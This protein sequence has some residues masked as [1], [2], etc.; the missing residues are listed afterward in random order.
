MGFHEPLILLALVFIVM[1]V[2][3]HYHLRRSAQTVTMDAVLILCGTRTMTQLRTVHVLLLLCRVLVIGLIVLL[4]SRPYIEVPGTAGSITERPV[5]LALVLDNSMSMRLSHGKE[6]SWSIAR[7]KAQK[8]LADLPHRSSVYLV[9][10]QKTPNVLFDET[11]PQGVSRYIAR[12]SPTL[13]GGDLCAAVKAAARLVRLTGHQERH[14]VVISDFFDHAFRSSLEALDLKDIRVT[15]LDVAPEGLIANR[16]VVDAVAFPAP[17]AGPNHVKV[18]AVVLNDQNILFDEVVTASIGET[19]VARRLVCNP[20]SR[21]P[22][23]FLLVASP[24]ELSGEVWISADNLPDDDRRFFPLATRDQGGI[25]LVNGA[26]SRIEK[27]DETFFLSRALSARVAEMQSFTIT[28]VRPEELSPLHLSTA[29][30]VVLANVTRLMPDQV[31]AIASFVA[32]GHGL[33]VTMGDNVLIE[34]E[35]SL[36]PDL[37][38]AG[39]RDVVDY[40]GHEALRWGYVENHP[41]LD[42]LFSGPGSLSS[43]MVNRYAVLEGSWPDNTRVIARLTNDAPIMVERGLGKGVVLVLLTS[44][45]RDW[46]DMPLRPVYAPFVMQ[47]IAWLGALGGTGGRACVEVGES[48]HIEITKEFA[49]AVVYTPSGHEVR[50]TTSGEFTD[51]AQ[52]GS[53]RIDFYSHGQA[54]IAKQ[55]FF[56]VNTDASESYL[57]RSSGI[58]NVLQ[59]ASTL[60]DN[61]LGDT[62]R[63][64]SLGPALLIGILLLLLTEAYLRGRA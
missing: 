60:Q 33:L 12:L 47:M 32:S 27:D 42:G 34:H 15:L 54:S 19:R 14:I 64:L 4:F 9:L 51:T 62:M 17:D 23:E 49:F 21:C 37:L 5:A 20:K 35:A 56:I 44:I 36:V 45:D 10:A 50:L 8:L 22:V 24:K 59:S 2:A 18:K 53:Y 26:V 55:D 48:R 11:S 25:L 43:V 58:P 3:I 28:V 63:R 1:P 39:I 13:G 40:R 30:A 6:T 38:P 61:D 57:E 29:T 52:P 41:V 31:Q 46:T 16:A 7:S